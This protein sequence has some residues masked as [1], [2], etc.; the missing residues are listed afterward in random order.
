MTVGE[1]A[2][3]LLA[4]AKYTELYDFLSK[5]DKKDGDV[6]FYLSLCHESGYGTPKNKE[7]AVLWLKRAAEYGSNDALTLLKSI[8]PDKLI[9]V[10]FS[11]SKTEYYAALCLAREYK[12]GAYINRNMTE[13]FSCFSLAKDEFP[14]ALYEVG[15]CFETG[16]GTQRNVELAIDEYISAVEK[17]YA[18]AE[19]ALLRLKSKTEEVRRLIEDAEKLIPSAQYKLGLCYEYGDGTEEIPEYAFLLYGAAEQAGNADAAFRLGFMYEN[20]IGTP[21]KE[22]KAFEMYKKAAQSGKMRYALALARCFEYGIGT[23]ADIKKSAH[24]Y[25][26]ECEKGSI[27]AAYNIA[28]CAAEGKL[29]SQYVRDIYERF[30]SGKLTFTQNEADEYIKD[31]QHGDARSQFYTGILYGFAGDAEHD[32]DAYEQF[33]YSSEKGFTPALFRLGKV[34]EIGKGA[35]KDEETARKLYEQAAAEGF[36]PACYRLGLL[37]LDEDD[38]RAA[39]AFTQAA[40]KGHAPSMLILSCMYDLGKGTEENPSYAYYLTQ[41]AR[42]FY[43]TLISAD[44]DEIRSLTYTYD[45]ALYLAGLFTECANPSSDEALSFYRAAKEKGSLQAHFRIA[46]IYSRGACGAEKDDYKA[47][48]LFREAADYG[49]TQ[50]MYRVGIM[51]RDGI[52]TEKDLEKAFSVLQA[53]ATLENADAQLAL[54]EFYE[55]GICC[56]QD[57]SEALDL[58]RRAA[59]NKNKTAREKV[60][61]R[62]RTLK[63]MSIDFHAAKNGDAQAQ[64]RLYEAYLNGICVEENEDE[65]YR[66]LGRAADGGNT[67]AQYAL[68][69]AYESGIYYT[70]NIKKAIYWYK[71]S[72]AKGYEP[73]VSRLRLLDEERELH[74]LF[75]KSFS[76]PDGTVPLLGKKKKAILACAKRGRVWAMYLYAFF[77]DMTDTNDKGKFEAL[78][79]YKTAAAKGYPL[80]SYK[81]GE[82]IFTLRQQG[83]ITVEAFPFFYNA[84]KRNIKEAMYMTALCYEIGCGTDINPFMA[85]EWYEKARE[86]GHRRSACALGIIYEDGR[87]AE[88]DVKKAESLYREANTSYAKYRLS[89]LL[90][91][92]DRQSKEGINLMLESAGEGN[93][94]AQIKC[95][96]WKM[97]GKYTARDDKAAYAYFCAAAKSGDSMALYLTGLCRETGRGTKKS[98]Q[99]AESSYQQAKKLYNPQAAYALSVM[100]RETDGKRSDNLLHDAAKWGSYKAYSELK[101]TLPEEELFHELFRIERKPSELAKAVKCGDGQACFELGLCFEYGF[102]V[103]KDETKAMTLYKRASDGGLCAATERLCLLYE[104]GKVGYQGDEAYRLCMTAKE[105][106]SGLCAKK[107]KGIYELQ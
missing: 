98:Q 107:I 75:E 79:W 57:G 100:Y 64:Y 72:A 3:K 2:G 52:G 70:R 21:K 59:K 77:L 58:Y 10:Y 9:S 67:A 31:A 88:R 84:A 53:A 65:A 34:V 87:G 92:E 55:K 35:Q 86:K 44:T 69:C 74:A 33:L 41:Q 51:Y 15:V 82:M 103:E 104:S 96:I 24:I 91:R 94:Y 81:A 89:L 28:R 4:D 46:D 101:K 56:L 6:C 78:T 32:T 80:C 102:N 18:D 63:M 23:D 49:S 22:Q 30:S 76:D 60:E 26:E 73:S 97:L 43:S 37:L 38:E 16:R 45:F 8:T 27:I 29:K 19:K 48:G 13:A 50:A 7:L 105:A 12:S 71:L 68:G 106:G 5:G 62:M 83:K 14:E 42:H 47:F 85:H 93:I 40:E 95:G 17:G 90:L 99:G 25:K 54:G 39:E 66:W 11:L 20:G 61:E 36:T 1:N